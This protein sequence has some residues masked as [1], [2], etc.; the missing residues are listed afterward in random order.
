MRLQTQELSRQLAAA[1]RRLPQ[2]E[3][4]RRRVQELEEQLALERRRTE[5]LSHRLEDPGNAARWRPLEGGDPDLEQLAAKIQVLEDRLDRKREAVL[6]KELVLEE[7]P[8]R[9]AL[10][11]SHR[12]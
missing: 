8:S 1:Q 2:L 4:D 11:S 7:V 12:T 3:Q 9:P 10:S 6:D 5:S